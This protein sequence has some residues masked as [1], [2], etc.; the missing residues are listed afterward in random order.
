MKAKIQKIMMVLVVMFFSVLGMQ[1]SA[2]ATSIVDLQNKFPNGAYWNHV[3]RSGHRYSGYNDV[4]GCNNP[5]GY[6]WTPCNTHNGNVGVGGYD[7]NSFSGG[8]QCNGFAK[9]LGYDLYGSTYTSWGR[10]SIGNAKCG[11]VIHYYGAGADASYGHWAMIIGRNGTTITLGEANAGGRCKIS[12]GRSINT[13]SMSSYTIYSAPWTATYNSDTEKPSIGD[14]RITDVNKDGYTITCTVSDNVGVTAVKFPSWC[15]D[16]HTGDN[17][18]W[19]EGSVSGNTASCRVNI[20]SLKSGARQGNYMT[21]IYAYDAAGNWG[22]K[23]IS[24]SCVYIDRTAPVIKDVEVTEVDNTGYTVT[25]TATDDKGI[26]RVQFPT[27]TEKDGQDDLCQNWQTNA[28]VSGT[29]DGDTYTFRV[30]DSD[31]KYERGIYHTHIYAYDN[32]GNVTMII[33]DDVEVKNDLTGDKAIIYNGHTYVRYED[34]MTWDEANAFCKKHLGY[35]LAINTEE[36][37]KIMEEFIADG[38]RY[39]YHIGINDTEKEGSFVWS[40]GEKV[41]YTNWEPNEPNDYGDGED[42]GQIRRKSGQWNDNSI[43]DLSCGFVMELPFDVEKVNSTLLGGLNQVLAKWLHKD[44]SFAEESKQPEETQAK[45][46]ETSAAPSQTP[47]SKETIDKIA[48]SPEEDDVISDDIEDDDFVFARKITIK[49]HSGYYKIKRLRLKATVDK[50]AS[51]KKITWSSSNKKYVSVNFKGKLTIKKAGIGKTVSITAKA[52]DGSRVQKVLKVK[53][54][55]KAG[56]RFL[57]KLR[58]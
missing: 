11:D 55:K 38:K 54:I 4:G 41:T 56:K 57:I 30:K 19:L 46:P 21:H 39:S 34:I 45:T 10:G 18:V 42:Y 23:A 20:S 35:L 13:T 27:W 6:T 5:D 25:C 2:N 40:S 14:V 47:S 9:K 43:A 24:D 28:A 32:A 15:N 48:D 8:M 1:V 49:N 17:A 58:K 12:W 29:K 37:Q 36:E 33:A 16:I 3:V 50:K 22:S 51:I 44:D 26:N 52:R 31:H 53:V 7:C